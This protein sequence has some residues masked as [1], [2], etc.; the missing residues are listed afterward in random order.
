MADFLLINLLSLSV[1]W[2]TF[3]MIQSNIN[4]SYIL[5]VP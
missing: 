5:A 1:P 4:F 2:G 3:R